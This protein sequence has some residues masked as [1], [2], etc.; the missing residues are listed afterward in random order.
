MRLQLQRFL[1]AV[2]ALGFFVSVSPVQ[3]STQLGTYI[4]IPGDAGVQTQWKSFVTAMGRTPTIMLAY[5]D[6]TQQWTAIG[7]YG[8]WVAGW[9][10][11]T[12]TPYLAGVTPEWDIYTVY[13][14][15]GTKTQQWQAV[16][17]G[18]YD[19]QITQ[20]LQAFK[21]QG[22]TSMYLR[23][24]SEFNGS[25][26]GDYVANAT[27]ATNFVA[28][29]RRI[30]T[31]AHNFQAS[32]G[33]KVMTE[34]NPNSSTI[35]PSIDATYPGDSYVDMIGLDIYSFS[36]TAANDPGSQTNV[37]PIFLANYAKA[38][39]K[40]FSLPETG[41][42]DAAWVSSMGP[43]LSQLIS[44]GV[45]FDHMSLWDPQADASGYP[46]RL[47]EGRTAHCR[48]AGPFRR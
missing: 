20:A 37:T 42:L 38:H 8:Q 35:V 12:T 44:S 2:I 15:P 11:K 13:A 7:S 21:D 18:T 30:A 6:A 19:A 23:I 48:E 43:V 5:T 25:W 32:S 10:N 3:A 17:N 33:M 46:G 41:G 16:A 40:P 14:G 31:V 28:A 45:V 29:W 1:F 36:G 47:S 27:D 22:F 4:G 24:G 34:W 39:G 9:F 26:S